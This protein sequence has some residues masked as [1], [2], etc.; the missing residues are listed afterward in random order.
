MIRL[1]STQLKVYLTLEY[2]QMKRIVLPLIKLPDFHLTLCLER[3]SLEF[4]FMNQ[5][6]MNEKFL[7]F[8]LTIGYIL[9]L[10]II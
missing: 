10:L 5:L 4:R 7:A 6:G 2:N 1:I 8:D 9:L 3:I